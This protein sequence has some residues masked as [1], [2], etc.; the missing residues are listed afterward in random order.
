MALIC[1]RRGRG[2]R[3]FTLSEEKE[4]LFKLTGYNRGFPSKIGQEEV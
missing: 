4:I 1:M 3:E 2:K